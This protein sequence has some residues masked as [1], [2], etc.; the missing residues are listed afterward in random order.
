MRRM[1]T[2]RMFRRGQSMRDQRCSMG[3]LVL[4]FL[5]YRQF[6]NRCSYTLHMY[7]YS[8]ARIVPEIEFEMLGLNN[9]IL[10]VF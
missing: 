4:R 5:S 6:V 10:A 7:M 1:V 8:R 3:P 2:A 9:V